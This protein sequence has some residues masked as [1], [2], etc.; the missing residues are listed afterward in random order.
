[1]NAMEVHCDSQSDKHF[2]PVNLADSRLAYGRRYALLEF[3]PD[4]SEPPV[5]DCVQIYCFILLFYIVSYCLQL[6]YSSHTVRTEDINWPI[7]SNGY[8]LRPESRH[9][10]VG[11]IP[12]D[13][14]GESTVPCS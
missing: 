12:A 8:Q 3:Q 6:V 5:R 9:R 14:L 2:N 7:I 1:M 11:G 10:E 4:L 13:S